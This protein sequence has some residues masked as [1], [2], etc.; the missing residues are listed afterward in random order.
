MIEQLDKLKD[1]YETIKI[2]TLTYTK[3]LN[4][5]INI[6]LDND[7]VTKFVSDRYDNY[8]INFI[9][10]I[11]QLQHMISHISQYGQH[12][13]LI[14]DYEVKYSISNNK[15]VQHK[16]VSVIDNISININ[17]REIIIGDQMFILLNSN[18]IIIYNS[19]PINN[20]AIIDS[21]IYIDNIRNEIEKLNNFLTIIDKNLSDILSIKSNINKYI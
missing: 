16:H 15:F 3:N 13:N 4:N 17:N 6:I 11:D 1:M 18:D 9:S 10:E 19:D 8:M 20:D 7:V 2:N 21:N 14:F 5:I 12:N